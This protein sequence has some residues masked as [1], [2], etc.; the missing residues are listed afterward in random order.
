MRLDVAPPTAPSITLP[1]CRGSRRRRR[2]PARISGRGPPPLYLNP[3]R[4]T[5]KARGRYWSRVRDFFCKTEATHMAFV[6]FE[7]E[8]RGTASPFEIW[9][10]MEQ[11]ALDAIPAALYLCDADRGLFFFTPRAAALSGGGPA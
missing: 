8:R 11:R 6:N 4:G 3:P 2:L 7:I 9:A 1:T 5:F 10:A